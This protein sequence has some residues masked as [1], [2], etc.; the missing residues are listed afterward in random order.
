MTHTQPSKPNLV[1]ASEYVLIVGSG[2]AAAA[3]IATQQVAVTALPPLTALVALGLLNRHRLDQQLKQ[4]QSARHPLETG[5]AQATESPSI[6]PLMLT[7][8]RPETC[9]HRSAITAEIQVPPARVA[10][11]QPYLH[12]ALAAKRQAHTEELAQMLANL[13]QVG[14][15]LRQHRLEKG[16]SVEE[17]YQMTFI[18]PYI[19]NA[20]ESGDLRQ[21]PEP[22]YIRAFLRKYAMALGLDG[23]ALANRF[24][25]A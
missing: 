21:L 22:F 17:I 25:G 19:V 12:G 8:L 24:V 16:W 5:T 15:E 20:L 7:S 3:S 18:Q 10:P 2:A 13:R 9:V 23:A 6:S 4:S 11:P 1:M 14:A